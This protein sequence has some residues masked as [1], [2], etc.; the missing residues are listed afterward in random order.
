MTAKKVIKDSPYKWTPETPYFFINFIY[1]SYTYF[2][3]SLTIHAK[4]HNVAKYI[5]LYSKNGIA[6][7]F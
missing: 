7:T 4:F 1:F 5:I 2:S 6:A 3:N